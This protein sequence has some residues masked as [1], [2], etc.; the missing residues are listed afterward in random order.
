LISMANTGSASSES[1]G[2]DP[3]I[4]GFNPTG[5]GGGNWVLTGGGACFIHVLTGGTFDVG[6]KFAVSGAGISTT[7]L[8]RKLWV[9]VF[10]F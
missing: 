6:I 9:A 4:V 8:S 10:P 7:V 1:S 3:Q 2:S 5:G